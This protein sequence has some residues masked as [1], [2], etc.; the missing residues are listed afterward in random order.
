L[1]L[2]AR[3]LWLDIKAPHHDESVNGLFVDMMS[4]NGT[5]R[6]DPENYHGP[7][8]FYAAW[9][10]QYFLGREAW[11]IRIP[12]VIASCAWI[13]SIF[14]FKTWLNRQSLRWAA[15]LLAISPAFLYFS[16]HS[17]HEPWLVLGA[18]WFTYGA[19]GMLEAN[20]RR[21]FYWMMGGLTMMVLNK[22]AMI[23]H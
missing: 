20:K 2:A 11:V 22:E 19:V 12:V 16:R 1:A 6:Y 21:Y 18:I 15:A 8:H 5:F 23:I 9:L 17:I 13:P 10:S 4:R 14:L 3:V 7:W